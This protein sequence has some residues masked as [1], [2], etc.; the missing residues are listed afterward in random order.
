MKANRNENNNSIS[1]I[2]ISKQANAILLLIPS[3]WLFMVRNFQ[4]HI[5]ILLQ[6]C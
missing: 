6:C 4:G 2:Y 5:G 1:G 3:I